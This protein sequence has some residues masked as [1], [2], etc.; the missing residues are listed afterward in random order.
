MRKPMRMHRLIAILLLL[1]SRGKMKAQA[2]AEALE[3]SV[4]SIYRDIDT[5]CE[6]GVPIQT[7]TG[8]GGGIQL[9]EGYTVQVNQFHMDEMMQLYLTG[10][11]IYTGRSSSLSMQLK[12]TLM[13]LEKQLPAAYRHDIQKVKERFYFDDTPWWDSPK[14][15]PCLEQLR[16][17]V[18]RSN[19]LSIQ[20]MK[21]SGEHSTRTI[22]PYGLIVKQMDW[23][24]VAYCEHAG[25]IR[26]FKCE[27]ILSSQPTGDEFTIPHDFHLEQFWKARDISFKQQRRAEER[28]IVTVKIQ[29]NQQRILD[30]WEVIRLEQVG[31][32]LVADINMYSEEQANSLV[33]KILGEAEVLS[34]T[35]LRHKIREQLVILQ[36]RYDKIDS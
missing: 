25:E 6:A 3:T 29:S 26:I 22:S 14:S 12:N 9:M 32:D 30:N 11:G 8:P 33:M 15:M 28:Y 17:A 2:L 34:P 36:Q 27:R 23:Y 7:S 10:M 1:E 18:L 4:R 13:K 24:V 31:V 21:V 20:Y 16:S 5:L 19:R 35:R